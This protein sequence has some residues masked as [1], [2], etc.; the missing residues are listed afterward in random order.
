M[1]VVS[2]LPAATDIVAELGLLPALVGRTHEC[3]W[4]PGA[5][6]SVPVVTASGIDAERMGS[7]EI[8]DAVGGARHGGSSLYTLDT[9]RLAELRPDV[10]L[11]Q[12]LCDV[13]AM[14]YRS[15]ARAVRVLEGDTRVV[16]LEPRTLDEVFGCVESVAATLGVA[17]VGREVAARLRAR[18]DA[19]RRRVAGRPR[20]TVA[21]I[22]WLD[23]VW[24]AG[25]WVPDQ[26]E[27]AGGVSLLAG[28]G[29]HTDRIEW[30]R[31]VEARPEV[32][33][34]QP[35]GFAP[36]RTMAE[37]RSLT[38]RPGWADLPA[39]RA[40]RVWVLDGPAYFNRPGPRVARGVEVLAHVLH[41]LPV[42]PAVTTAE[43]RRLPTAP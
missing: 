42:E 29:E 40:G 33:V 26:I 6:E 25:H 20:P 21:A 24:P 36:D 13:C 23:P 15:V 39:V 41:D 18:V 22:E 28:S 3:D 4:P 38:E 43:A 11:T 32:V 12:D 17:E 30:T 7:R 5:V 16:S 37:L 9:G 35:C 14:S 31:V 2:L 8:S 34:I 27:A 1:R 19:V 10:V